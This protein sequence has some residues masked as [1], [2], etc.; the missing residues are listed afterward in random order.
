VVAAPSERR[1]KR[2][3]ADARITGVFQGTPPRAL[4]NG[5][6][7]RAGEMVDQTL[8]VF[9][10][11]DAEKKTIT[12]EDR[13]GHPA[14]KEILKSRQV[15]HRSSTGGARRVKDNAPY[16]CAGSFRTSEPVTTL[17]PNGI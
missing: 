8:G 5:R 14:D 4:I 12:F 1:F 9:D 16:L 13:T 11:I 6:M 7:I 10:S 17:S 2:F 3:V 15:R